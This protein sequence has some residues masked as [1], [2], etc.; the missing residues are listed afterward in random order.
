[1]NMDFILG[2]A[3]ATTVTA[4]GDAALVAKDTLVA[5]GGDVLPYAAVILALTAGWK[6]AKKFLRG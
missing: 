1:M 2:A 6:F 3:D 4:V 5:V